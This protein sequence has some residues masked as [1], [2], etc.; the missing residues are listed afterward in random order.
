MSKENSVQLKR[1]IITAAL[2][3]LA[4][5]FAI[6]SASFAWY[7]YNT[8]A[9]TTFVHMAAGSTISL[10]IS[11]EYE[12]PYQSSVELVSDFAGDLVP[13]STDKVLNGFNTVTE[14]SGRPEGKKSLLAS[15]FGEVEQTEYYLSTLFI[16]SSDSVG[17]YLSN[18]GYDD[19]DSDYLI[20]TAIR[21]G[22]LV[23]DPGNNQPVNSEYIFEIN[24]ESN[25]DA[26]YNTAKGYEGCV[27]DSSKFG[28]GS[29][30]VIEFTPYNSDNYC[31]HNVNT[32]LTELKPNSLKL[33]DLPDDEEAVQV[34]VYI[35]LEGCDEDCMNNL[36]GATLENLA[37]AFVGY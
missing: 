11:N 2:A 22:L 7:I 8:S 19:K 26:E 27:L 31:I 35:W 4:A 9:H 13:V 10:Q 28:T 5:L 33:C 14:F 6:I 21:V 24:T 36:V 18:I 3:L 25:P 34:D 1:S 23:H 15:L 32:G 20:S 16:K 37:L 29:W 12:G 30:D 17:L